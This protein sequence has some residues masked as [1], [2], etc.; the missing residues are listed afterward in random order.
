[1]HVP[2]AITD[3]DE[4]RATLDEAAGQQ[5]TLAKGVPAFIA[6]FG[7]FGVDVKGFAGVLGADEE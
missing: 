7:G 6:D 3:G 5:R 1:V 4:T 2:S